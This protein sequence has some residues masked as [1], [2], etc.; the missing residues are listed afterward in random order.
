MC[1]AMTMC[2]GIAAVH[3]RAR[4]DTLKAGELVAGLDSQQADCCALAR[5]LGFEML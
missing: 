1:H 2:K 5:L 3:V 4:G